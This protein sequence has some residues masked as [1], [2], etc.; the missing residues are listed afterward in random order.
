MDAVYLMFCG[1]VALGV[2]VLIRALSVVSL[3]LSNG[4]LDEE[5]IQ[6]AFSLH[7]IAAIFTRLGGL[8][9]LGGLLWYLPS[10]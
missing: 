4:W 7:V 9:L 6:F 10:L 5:D 3:V 1:G 2:A 8:A